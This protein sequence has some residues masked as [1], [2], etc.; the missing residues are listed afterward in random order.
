MIMAHPFERTVVCPPNIPRSSCKLVSSTLRGNS[1]SLLV[2][3][4][5]QLAVELRSQ[6]TTSSI[7][8][9][10][11]RRV[12]L[13]STSLGRQLSSMYYLSPFGYSYSLNA[14]CT[15]TSLLQ[16]SLSESTPPRDRS[17]SLSSAAVP[18]WTAVKVKSS[19]QSTRTDHTN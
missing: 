5:G 18:P 15:G 19:F 11:L 7:Q 14:L 1:L 6:T 4:T 3:E 8:L 9:H 2:S 13:I 10:W 17:L 16:T 12:E